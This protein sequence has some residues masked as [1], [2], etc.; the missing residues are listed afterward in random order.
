MN[1]NMGA[2]LGGIAEPPR[3]PALGA[4]IAET[5]LIGMTLLGLSCFYAFLNT[6]FRKT[7]SNGPRVL[8]GQNIL[9]AAPLGLALGW[10]YFTGIQDMMLFY[11]LILP[12]GLLHSWGKM[13]TPGRMVSGSSTP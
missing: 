2:P 9:V 11:L 13:D 4:L 6:V 8:R 10:T 3:P 1:I 7:R 5:G 12:F